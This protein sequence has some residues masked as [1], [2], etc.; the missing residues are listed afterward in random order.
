[1]GLNINY[2]KTHEEIGIKSRN[3]KIE[4]YSK[5]LVGSVG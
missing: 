1:M 3:I 2:H 5:C 4:L